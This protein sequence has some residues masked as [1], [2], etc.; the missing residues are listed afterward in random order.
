MSGKTL[1]V[2]ENHI[3]IL[4]MARMEECEWILPAVAIRGNY[5]PYFIYVYVFATV[6]YCGARLCVGTRRDSWVNSHLVI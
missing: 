3:P 2:G 1:L 4:T 5:L 6:V